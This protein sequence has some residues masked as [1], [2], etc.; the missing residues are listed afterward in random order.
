MG[1]RRRSSGVRCGGSYGSWST[2]TVDLTSDFINWLRLIEIDNTLYYLCTSYSD[3]F[4]MKVGS[5]DPIQL[6]LSNDIT[7]IYPYITS[8][9]SGT[10]TTSTYIDV[11]L[12]AGG[13]DSYPNAT[14][15]YLRISKTIFSGL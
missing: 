15:I 9:K 14:N 1:A 7:G 10:P 2:E 6:S 8:P 3:V 11:L 4:I 13:S 5:T 12:L